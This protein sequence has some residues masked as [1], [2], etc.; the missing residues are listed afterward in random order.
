MASRNY[1]QSIDEISFANF[2]KDLRNSQLFE[3]QTPDTPTKTA[4][5]SPLD[6]WT[7]D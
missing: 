5:Q 7:D 6:S 4:P 3:I 2:T 1:S